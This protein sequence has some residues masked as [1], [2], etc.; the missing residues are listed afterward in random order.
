MSLISFL[1]SMAL[2]FLII[3]GGCFLAATIFCSIFASDVIFVLKDLWMIMLMAF[4]SSLTIF[5][6][7]SKREMSKKST[8]YRKIIQFLMVIICIFGIG[9]ANDWIDKRSIP[10]LVVMFLLVASIFSAI[11]AY[12][13]ILNCKMADRIN[14]AL[15]K[16]RENNHDS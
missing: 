14:H 12:N 11:S 7:Y 2:N 5:V 1:K 6:Y 8:I 9:F 4:T 16:L 13:Y 15:E 3:L 10:Q